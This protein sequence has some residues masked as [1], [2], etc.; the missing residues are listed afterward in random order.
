MF[1]GGAAIQWTKWPRVQVMKL[2]DCFWFMWCVLTVLTSD[3]V[4]FLQKLQL[5]SLKNPKGPQAL[6][7]IHGLIET[8]D[9]ET[10]C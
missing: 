5:F 3:V 6:V 2:S 8:V 10:H 9:K 4:D 1:A 7:G